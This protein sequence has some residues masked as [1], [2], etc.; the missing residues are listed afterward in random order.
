VVARDGAA[1]KVAHAIERG[2]DVAHRPGRAA[3][4]RTPWLWVS[5]QARRRAGP[6]APGQRSRS[7][8]VRATTNKTDPYRP[9]GGVPAAAGEP[10][11]L[12]E[13]VTFV[14][15]VAVSGGW[16]C[17]GER[18]RVGRRSGS[19]VAGAGG[20]GHPT[21][22]RVARRSVRRRRPGRGR[23]G[24]GR[25]RVQPGPSTR[26]R[27]RRPGMT[28]PSLAIAHHHTLGVFPPRLRRARSWLNSAV[29]VTGHRENGPQHAPAA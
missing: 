7:H 18:A 10:R 14:L 26:R 4:R 3:P 13:P 8:K 20:D 12:I 2:G 15:G 23:G 22:A 27:R 5:P 9:E 16:R 19:T 24:R 25:G 17:R 11:R 1:G 21:L 28:T 6:R 29:A